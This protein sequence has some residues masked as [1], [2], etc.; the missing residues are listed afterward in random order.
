MIKERKL[1]HHKWQSS[2][3][4]HAADFW[5]YMDKDWEVKCSALKDKYEWLKNRALMA[6][7]VTGNSRAWC[8][9]FKAKGSSLLSNGEDKLA[10]WAKHFC[11]ALNRLAPAI[12]VQVE[13]LQD[14]LPINTE[15]FMEEEIRKAMNTCKNNRA[16]CIDRISIEMMKAGGEMVVEWK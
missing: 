1:L 9:P 16:P 3:S 15:M 8:F 4:D 14:T 5:A 7:I 6:K 2:S 11:K 13:D 10:R 12:P